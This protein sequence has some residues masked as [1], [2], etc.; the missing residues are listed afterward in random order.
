MAIEFPAMAYKPGAMFEW[1]GETF[2]Y[3][4]VADQDELDI[5]LS[6]GWVIGKP[7]KKAPK[8]KRAAPEG[9]AE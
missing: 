8:A 5:A 6:D 2:D 7:E 3:V 4:I 9:D 1:D